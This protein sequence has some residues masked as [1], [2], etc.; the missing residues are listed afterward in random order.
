MSQTGR[1]K[2]QTFIPHSSGGWE[3]KIKVPSD[4]IPGETLFLAHS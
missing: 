1:L 2:Q 4:F 3:S